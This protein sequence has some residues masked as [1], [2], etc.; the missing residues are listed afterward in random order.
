MTWLLKQNNRASYT[1]KMCVTR[2]D[3]V[4]SDSGGGARAYKPPTGSQSSETEPSYS[5]QPVGPGGMTVIGC[6]ALAP[7]VPVLWS[8]QWSRSPRRWRSRRWSLRSGPPRCP[9]PRFCLS[10][11][12]GG[13]WAK[14]RSCSSCSCPTRF[15]ASRPAWT[16]GP[17]RRR[18]SR[19]TARPW[20]RRRTHRWTHSLWKIN[21]SRC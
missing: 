18:C 2:I 8:P 20:C 11:S 7:T 16:P 12:R 10:C 9:S 5:A 1:H 17:S 13:A 6:G 15:P 3:S 14:G 4:R 21:S 19:R